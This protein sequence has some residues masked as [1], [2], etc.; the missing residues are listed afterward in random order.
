MD[1]FSER[2]GHNNGDGREPISDSAPDWLRLLYIDNI[3]KQYVELGQNNPPIHPIEVDPLY[4]T[5]E[6]LDLIIIHFR[7]D[8]IKTSKAWKKARDILR[9]RE[10][11]QFYSFVELIGQKLKTRLEGLAEDYI[12]IRNSGMDPEEYGGEEIEWSLHYRNYMDYQK[13]VNK[14]FIESEV[15]WELDDVG[16]LKRARPDETK[17]LFQDVKEALEIEH[18]AAYK[19]LVKSDQYVS[20]VHLDPENAIKEIVSAV[21]SLV[22]K[23]FPSA[24][25]LSQGLKEIRKQDQLPQALVSLIDKFYAYASNEPGVRHGSP[26]ESRVTLDEAEFCI[27]LGNAIIR[28][29][30]SK[31]FDLGKN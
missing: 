12:L 28:Y 17:K 20:I 31:E 19:H 16:Y 11:H 14:L 21:E 4:S 8:K 7:L 22:R 1:S 26:R 23:L 5:E 30:N 6:L 10:W 25:T 29:L 27:Y 13:K 18:P 9:E 2:H 15:R 3:L 24:Q